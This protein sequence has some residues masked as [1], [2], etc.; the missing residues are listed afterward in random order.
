[1]RMRSQ[2]P[3]DYELLAKHLYHNYLNTE[4]DSPTD[5]EEVVCPMFNRIRRILE[6]H[7]LNLMC[8]TVPEDSD[9]EL[10]SVILKHKLEDSFID[11]VSVGSVPGT[12]VK[13]EGLFLMLPLVLIEQLN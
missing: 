5:P 3:I 11:W 1:M 2:V 10:T 4:W 9:T 12:V 8:E 13:V 7:T 6:Q